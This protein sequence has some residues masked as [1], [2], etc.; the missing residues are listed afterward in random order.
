MLILKTLWLELT[1]PRVRE[2]GQARQEYLTRVIFT[3][4]SA[5]LALMTVIVLIIN[6]GIGEADPS[7]TV[8]MLGMDTMVAIGWYL[9]GK[10]YWRLGGG[11]LP[12]IFLIFSGYMV[13]TVG[14]V[15]TA[16]L[17]LAIAILL[18]GM[19][20]GNRARWIV[21]L[22]SI[23]IYLVAGW[24]SGERD[25]EIFLT[26]GILL[27]VSLAGITLLEWFFSNLLQSSLRTAN[28]REAKLQ[29]IFRAA[30]IGIGMVINRIIY[31]AN[32]TLCQ[33]TGYTR[34]ELIGR[35][36][37]V[38]YPSQ[39]DYEY[40]GAEKYRQ[41]REREVGTVETRWRR[42]NGEIRD[43]LL[44]SVPLDPNDWGRGVTFSALD[45]TERK[46]AENK[47]KAL[48]REKEILL[49]EV[50]HRV[51]NNMQVITSLLNLQTEEVSDHYTRALLEESRNRIQS[52]ALVHEQLYRSREYASISFTEYVN[53]LAS[54]L[55]AMYQIDAD[56]V[57]LEVEAGSMNLDLE[58]AIPCGLLLNELITN[59][60]KYA[61]PKGRKG[62]LW[63]RLQSRGDRLIIQVGDDGV[64]LPEN[65]DFR[66]TKSLGL[67][68]VNL[69]VEHDLGG[70]I[71]LERDRGTQYCIEFPTSSEQEKAL[72]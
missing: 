31:E 35:N 10:G 67:Q 30:P 9:I 51:K 45:I 28:E 41:I 64:G 21:L 49:A 8:I 60:L 2:E 66:Q 20:Y 5:G 42:K 69:L 43:V 55:F 23:L 24:G 16:V 25:I 6:Y 46:Q 4:V 34:D 26:S 61:F 70:K 50:H 13:I 40:V 36:A 12:A 19:L 54:T 39:E 56:D 37:R 17:Q 48:L 38:L 62:K 53:Q 47:Q 15:T 59:S 33:M 22:I 29:S 72:A 52:M 68:L 58:R 27:S 7:S 44:S 11:L 18:A 3:M 63:V 32:D 1:N 14:P 71:M 65:F 57:H